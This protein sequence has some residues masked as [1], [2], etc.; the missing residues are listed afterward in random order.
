MDVTIV[1]AG[2]VGLVTGVSLA[3][4]GG[5]NVTWVEKDPARVVSLSNWHM[6]IHEPG[7]VEAFREQARHLRVVPSI[8]ALD[9]PPDIVLIAVATPI[10]KNGEPD[11]TQ[12]RSATTALRSLPETHVSVRSTLPPGTS[13]RL[14]AMLGRP[15]G[16]RVSTNPEF[17]REGAAMSDFAEPS[18]VVLGTYPETEPGHLRLLD[19]LLR[20]IHA[21]RQV[22]SVQAAEMIKNVANGFLALKLSF[23]NEIASL[24]EE[25]AVDVQD[26]LAG[27]ALDPRIG[28]E[29]MRPGLG[30]GG[31]CLPKELL[32][33]AAAGRRHGLA[34]HVARAVAVVN[35]EQ[36]Q[37]FARRIVQELGSRRSRV[38][39]L[40]LSFKPGTDDMRGSPAI[41]VAN[42]LEQAGHTVVAHDP[43]VSSQ[44]A[45]AVMPRLEMHTTVEAA[46]RASD[47]IV[48]A[49]DW[50]QY[51][52]LDWGLI[53]AQMRGTLVFDG[54][55]GL[56]ESAVVTAGLSYRGVGRPALEPAPRL[57]ELRFATGSSRA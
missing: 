11:L 54:R 1:G 55:N 47:A 40:G 14:P 30:F 46:A 31:S 13:L 50:P 41:T 22:V 36:Q 2:Y 18:R 24:C 25:Y 45:A 26:V 37:R 57:S 8:G 51:R 53:A 9:R 29:Y 38:A 48:L 7:L 19:E 5:H 10:G 21:P 42:R 35:E 20:G 33:L 39:M 6:P 15:D 3:R 52:H 12:L 4:I 17:L 28:S 56:N 32:V 34:M 49:T 44:R 23:V 16:G 43:A 27:I